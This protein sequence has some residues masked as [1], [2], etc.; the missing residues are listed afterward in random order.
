MAY[1]DYEYYAQVY[2]GSAVSPEDFPRLAER[3]S[4]YVDAATL[5]R[6]SKAAGER[7]ESVKKA[8]CALAEIIQDGERLERRTFSADRLVQSET[9]GSWSKSY[10]SQ[11]ATGIETG[12]LETRKRETLEI[13]LGPYGL[14]RA[15]G[16]RA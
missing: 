6:A 7:M 11:S 8:V 9:V 10:G 12:L 4:A 14:L 1:T 13:Y 15:R 5:H 2:F 16:Y 3:A